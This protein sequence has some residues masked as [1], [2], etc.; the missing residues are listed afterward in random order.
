MAVPRQA[1]RDVED[2]DVLSASVDAAHGCKRGGMFTCEC[3]AQETGRHGEVVRS[4]CR[5]AIGVP[6]HHRE[7]GES[8][9]SV[10]AFFETRSAAFEPMPVRPDEALK[11]MPA[12]ERCPADSKSVEGTSR[13]KAGRAE[14]RHAGPR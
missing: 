14:L 11:K 9:A 10:A 5:A 4:W 12:F 7:L 2:M 3:D 13:S 8:V 1:R 6:S